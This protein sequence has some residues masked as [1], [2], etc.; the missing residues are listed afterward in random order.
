MGQLLLGMFLKSLTIAYE[1]KNKFTISPNN[2]IF[3]HKKL[4][5]LTNNENSYSHKDCIKTI[6][7]NSIYNRYTCPQQLSAKG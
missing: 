7:S 1:V 5:I 3:L 2:Y 6:N 4:K